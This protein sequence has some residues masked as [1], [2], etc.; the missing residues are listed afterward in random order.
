MS[1]FS[2]TEAIKTHFTNPFK[3]LILTWNP[4]VKL[5]G[6]GICPHLC[7]LHTCTYTVLTHARWHTCPQYLPVLHSPCG[8]SGVDT[9]V[10]LVLYFWEESQKLRLMKR[11]LPRRNEG[12][13]GLCL[14]YIIKQRYTTIHWKMLIISWFTCGFHPKM[15]LRLVTLAGLWREPPEPLSGRGVCG[16]PEQI[17]SCVTGST[18]RWIPG[19][20]GILVQSYLV[21]FQHCGR[22][23]ISWSETRRPMPTR[24]GRDPVY[25]TSDALCMIQSVCMVRQAALTDGLTKT[26]P[27]LGP[28]TCFWDHF[29][30]YD[31]YCPGWV[32]LAFPHLF[33]PSCWPWR[34]RMTHCFPFPCR[35]RLWDGAG[36]V[37]WDSHVTGDKVQLIQTLGSALN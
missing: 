9:D 31:H 20:G 37:A 33:F 15:S 36:Y 34:K 17:M 14:Y 6:S 7:P 21:C 35:P 32:T 5:L 16:P 25:V 27:L 10:W 29:H 13:Q 19:A 3:L 30:R 4:N 2:Q 1:G 24:N 22:A 8:L 23:D 18:P 28:A 11:L 12:K 26:A